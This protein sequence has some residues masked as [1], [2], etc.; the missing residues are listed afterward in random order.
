M[1]DLNN[2]KINGKPDKNGEINGNG[3]YNIIDGL[4]KEYYEAH[5]DI[6]MLVKKL[7]NLND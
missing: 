2:Q 5:S 7:Q 6:M 4:L 1:E 3:S